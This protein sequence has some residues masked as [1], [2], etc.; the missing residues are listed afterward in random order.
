MRLPLSGVVLTVFR[1]RWKFGGPAFS[2]SDVKSHGVPYFSLQLGSSSAPLV[3]VLTFS[4]SS[5][6]AV[7]LCGCNANNSV[8]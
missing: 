7:S 8:T 1:G 5:I 6:S 2:R 3:V 4:P